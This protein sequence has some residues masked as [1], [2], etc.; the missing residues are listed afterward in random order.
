MFILLDPSSPPVVPCQAG[1]WSN[2]AVRLSVSCLGVL[3]ARV[4][5]F[6]VCIGEVRLFSSA[7][8]PSLP[9]SIYKSDVDVVVV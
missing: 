5:V 4:C 1:E 6:C 2:A 9:P 8:P 7:L 3:R